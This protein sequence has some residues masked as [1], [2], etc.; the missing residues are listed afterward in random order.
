MKN[1]YLLII[2][3]FLCSSC[4]QRVLTEEISFKKSTNKEL[5]TYKGK[6]FSGVAYDVIFPEWLNGKSKLKVEA[7][8][9]E[10]EIQKYIEYC[11]AGRKDVVKKEIIYKNGFISNE[12]GFDC[13]RGKKKY[14][15]S[16]KDNQK[17]G[18]WVNYQLENIVDDERSEE[19]WVEGKLA[20]RIDYYPADLDDDESCADLDD[21]E[22][23]QIR[24]IRDMKV[25]VKWNDEKKEWLEE[26]NEFFSSKL[27]TEIFPKIIIDNEDNYKNIIEFQ[28]AR[29]FF[30]NG[31]KE[32]DFVF[33]TTESSTGDRVSQ[34]IVY[35]VEWNEEGQIIS[36]E[37]KPIKFN[38]E[39][40]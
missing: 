23:A 27:F 21:D 14:E 36:T 22:K 2:T 24:E 28:L 18:I 17:H 12:T 4:S 26:E 29:Y 33:A 15:G 8:Y 9:K 20:Q 10:G 3:I 35:H 30:K 19:F 16:F 37:K 7:I 5:A 13:W 38:W 31:Q 6:L 39:S 34:N 11:E 32:N 1:L 25:K 40:Y